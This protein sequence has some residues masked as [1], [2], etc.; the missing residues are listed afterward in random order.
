M[1][2]WPEGS[3]GLQPYHQLFA[4]LRYGSEL[5]WHSCGIG[6][7][8]PSCGDLSNVDV[9]TMPGGITEPPECTSGSER[10]WHDPHSRQCLAYTSCFADEAANS[11]ETR[12][13]CEVTCSVAPDGDDDA[14]VPASTGDEDAS[15]P[16]AAMR[17]R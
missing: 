13:Q 16:T 3:G 12:E 14:S 5:R 17:Q 1:C 6:Q 10:F 7:A 15:T 8:P 11:F 9:C 2:S 4:C